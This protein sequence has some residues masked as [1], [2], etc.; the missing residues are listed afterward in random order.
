[1]NLRAKAMNYVRA[2][3]RACMQHSAVADSKQGLNLQKSFKQSTLFLFFLPFMCVDVSACLC[4]D[5]FNRSWRLKKGRQE[6]GD[7]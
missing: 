2:C 7:C 4:T 3:I 1:M 5:F 6:T